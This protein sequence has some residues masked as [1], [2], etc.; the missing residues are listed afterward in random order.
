[1]SCISIDGTPTLTGTRVSAAF[2][3]VRG[4]TDEYPPAVSREGGAGADVRLV[5][6]SENRSAGAAMGGRLRPF[7][8]G[9][10]FVMRVR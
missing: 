10:A 5:R 8:D 6:S 2:V 3:R 7:C 9:Q 1:M 4:W